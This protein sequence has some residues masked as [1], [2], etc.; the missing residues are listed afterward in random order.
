VSKYYI[1][2]FQAIDCMDFA[3]NNRQKAGELQTGIT[4]AQERIEVLK[5][6]LSRQFIEDVTDRQI[7]IRPRKRRTELNFLADLCC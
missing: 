1:N 7:L 6:I 4:T 3:K 2:T 5:D